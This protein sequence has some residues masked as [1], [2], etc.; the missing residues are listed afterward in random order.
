VAKSTEEVLEDL[1][2]FLDKKFG[3]DAERGALQLW[4]ENYDLRAQLNTA[5]GTIE[6]LNTELKNAQPGDDKQIVAKKDA[7]E[8]AQFRALG[9]FDDV[10]QSVARA[11]ELETQLNET[12]QALTFRDLQDVAKIKTSVLRKIAPA[13]AQYEVR[14]VDDPNNE[15]VKTKAVFIK[16]KDE[17]GKDAEAEIWDYARKNAEDFLPALALGTNSESNQSNTSGNQSGNVGG[18]QPR[19]I[20]QHSGSGNTNKK[21]IVDEM[22]EANNARADAPNALLGT[23]GAGNNK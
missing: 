16:Y 6:T 21:S 9:K 10:K 4:Q 20:Q 19:F 18:V 11:G 1:Q 7:E 23:L 12:K 15:G 8:L 13:D 14:D 17:S 2:K 5:K 3:G 22:L